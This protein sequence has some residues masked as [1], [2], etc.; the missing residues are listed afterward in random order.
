MPIAG[1]TR[2]C[3]EAPEGSTPERLAPAARPGQR[4]GPEE[5]AY[6]VIVPCLLVSTCS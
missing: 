6:Q 4:K 1:G 5:R 2:G 3:N